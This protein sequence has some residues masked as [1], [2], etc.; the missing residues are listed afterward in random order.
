[1]NKPLFKSLCLFVLWNSSA[2]IITAK[3]IEQVYMK[4]GSIVEGYICEQVPGKSITV[5]SA[6]ATIIVG[7]DS[8]QSTTERE[9]NV[10]D[11]SAPWQDWAEEQLKLSGQSLKLATLHFANIEYKDVCIVEQGSLI[12][13]IDFT[14]KQYT[15]SWNEMYKT[16]K[17]IRPY[18]QFSGVED[19]LLLNDGTRYI[20]QITEQYPGKSIKIQ[21]KDDNVVTVKSAQVVQLES[22]PYSKSLTIMQQTPLLDRLFLKEQIEPIEGYIVRRITNKD[23]T[24]VTKEGNSKV[25]AMKDISKY[26]KFVNAD[27]Q[28]ILDKKLPIGE[29]LLNGEK[30]WFATLQMEDD[31]IILSE[32]ASAQV[33]AGDTITI[34]AQLANAGATVSMVKAY[35]KD[36]SILDKK[37]KAEKFRDVFTYRDLVEKALPYERSTTPLGN[38]KI[39]FIAGKA[40]DYVISVQGLKGYIVINVTDRKQ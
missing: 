36:L 35:R 38:T 5:Q 13:F 23:L 37:A 15:F 17:S 2:N 28:V 18:N 19:V 27:Y 26:Q 9:V 7:S 39:Q 40:G 12:K 10:N 25:V 30:A 21:T 14:P 16:V 11:L 32:E 24:I 3:N 4:N 20:G 22:T 6:K 31:Y 34:E 1:M 29:V 33:T 8:L